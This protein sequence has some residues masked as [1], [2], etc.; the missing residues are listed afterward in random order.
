MRRPFVWMAVP[1]CLYSVFG[2]V[3]RINIFILLIISLI[4]FSMIISKTKTEYKKHFFIFL[5][6]FCVFSI[7]CI[8]INSRE[9][10]LVKEVGTGGTQAI[11]TGSVKKVNVYDERMYVQLSSVDVQAGNERS[12][13]KGVLLKAPLADVGIGDEV[14]AKGKLSEFEKARNEGNFDPE[15]Y[16]RSIGI[17]AVADT[18][19]QV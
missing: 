4:I 6:V 9:N 7:I 17:E 15:S 14:T 2:A 12:H 19:Q 10:T 3:F 13:L 16:Y 11:V 8:G 5:S 18:K 1:V